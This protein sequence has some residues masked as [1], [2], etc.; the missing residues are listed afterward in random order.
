MELVK[1]ETLAK[2][3]IKEHGLVLWSFEFDNSKR[4][5]GCCFHGRNRITLSKSLV[6]L[7]DEARVRNTILHEIAHAL[8]GVGHGHDAVWKS[9][10]IQIGCDGNRCYS[11]KEVETPEAK[12]QAVCGKCNHIHKRHRQPRKSTSCGVC[13]SRYDPKNLLVYK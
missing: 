7:N 13:S 1:A 10:A 11:T 6:L 5:F 4:R 9:I 2:N 12:Y 8:V 3:L